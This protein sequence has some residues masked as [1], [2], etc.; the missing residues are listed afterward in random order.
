MPTTDLPITSL[1]APGD[2]DEGSSRPWLLFR[3]S[4][5]CVAALVVVQAVLAGG[6]LSGHYDALAAH[7]VIGGVAAA[8]ML[9]QTITSLVLWRK[10]AIPSWTVRVSLIQLI[11]TGALIVLG[12]QRILGVHVPLAVLL[13]VGVALSLLHAWRQGRR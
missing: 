11:I 5:G 13:T 6:F 12:Q 2:V 3:V 9:L 7:A 4:T 10:A 1:S 8:A